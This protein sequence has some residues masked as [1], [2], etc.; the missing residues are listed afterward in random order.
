MMQRCSDFSGMPKLDYEEWRVLLRS[1]CGQYNPE[2][3]EPEV[4]AGPANTSLYERH[5]FEIVVTIQVGSRPSIFPML[6]RAR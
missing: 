1:L 6:R 4:F 3:I 2:G 5:G